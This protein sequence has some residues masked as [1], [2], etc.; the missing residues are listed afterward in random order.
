ME[1]DW[2]VPRG[3]QQVKHGSRNSNDVAQR[4]DNALRA[5]PGG[6]PEE[7]QLRVQEA[8]R[9]EQ[10]FLAAKDSK[11]TSQ[12]NHAATT[13]PT[14]PI[15]ADLNSSNMNPHGGSSSSSSSAGPTAST[16]TATQEADKH[17][18]ETTKEFMGRVAAEA[19]AKAL[20]AS[21]VQF[22]EEGKRLGFLDANGALKKEHAPIGGTKRKLGEDGDEMAARKAVQLVEGIT[23]DGIRITGRTQAGFDDRLKLIEGYIRLATALKVTLLMRDLVIDVMRV[24]ISLRQASFDPTGSSAEPGFPNSHL[25]SKISD[26]PVMQ[27]VDNL[28]AFMLLWGFKTLDYSGISLRWFE[29][30]EEQQSEWAQEATRQG[31]ESLLRA[32][33][34]LELTMRIIWDEAFK[35]AL[36]PFQDLANNLYKTIANGFIRFYIELM[37]CNWAVDIRDRKVPRGIYGGQDEFGDPLYPITNAKECAALLKAYAVDLMVRFTPV[38]SMETPRTASQFPLLPPPHVGFFDVGGLFKGVAN[39]T[40]GYRKALPPAPANPLQTD[41]PTT[42]N[43]CMWAVAKHFNVLNQQGVPISGCPAPTSCTNV[44][45]DTPMECKAAINA[46]HLAEWPVSRKTADALQKSIADLP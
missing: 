26:L 44:H 31:K 28:K 15:P 42:G 32:L 11:K 24:W 29:A 45:F 19:S 4:Y 6:L 33:A 18:A 22:L 2:Q 17:A 25:A 30:P 14:Q 5:P 3:A 12:S 9:N 27:D 38:T 35:E 16:L 8:V 36:E 1:E 46:R 23:L 37:I 39:P 34:R 10:E 20:V 21:K 40:A 43:P 13:T 41:S 7:L